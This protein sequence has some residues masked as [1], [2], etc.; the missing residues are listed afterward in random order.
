LAVQR[1]RAL[2]IVRTVELARYFDAAHRK[3]E[4]RVEL[5]REPRH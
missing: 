2:R 1:E 3:R 5:A 4:R